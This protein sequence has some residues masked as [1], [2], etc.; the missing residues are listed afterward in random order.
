VADAAEVARIQVGTWRTAYAG[1]IAD[2]VLA[3]LSEE[4]KTR[5]WA[6]RLPAAPPVACLVA[7]SPPVG[8]VAA[9]PPEA[10]GAVG[11]T[12]TG[13]VYAI[14]VE[15]TSWG[16][17]LGRDLLAAAEDRLRAAGFARA[18]LWVLTTNARARAFYERQGWSTTG[19]TQVA[20]LHGATLH[21]TRYGVELG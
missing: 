13:E 7:G 1:L 16:R 5:A 11:E 10:V 18:G 4:R 3:G 21:E 14:Y 20:E 8:F 19:E 2:D 17:G 9:G 12:G 6:D 15:P